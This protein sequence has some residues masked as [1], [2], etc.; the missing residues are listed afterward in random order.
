MSSQSNTVS[1]EGQHILGPK[2]PVSGDS[3]CDDDVVVCQVDRRHL[4]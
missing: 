3:M 2:V 4:A 1:D